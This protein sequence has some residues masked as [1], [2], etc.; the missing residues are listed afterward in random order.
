[1]DPETE[2]N[3]TKAETDSHIQNLCMYLESTTKGNFTY[4]ELP[5]YAPSDYKIFRN[6]KV[7]YFVE[8]K[9][10]SHDY[11][12]YTD[13]KVPISKYCFGYTFENEYKVKC[14]LLVAWADAKAGI[15]RLKDPDRIDAMV[16][17]HDR[18]EG[19]DLYAFYNYDNFKLLNI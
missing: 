13:E 6:G 7:A 11:G 4:E 15:I 9:V 2:F 5:K 8:V 18:G 17:R 12:Y 10:R 16:A 14:L 1:M 19:E 3:K